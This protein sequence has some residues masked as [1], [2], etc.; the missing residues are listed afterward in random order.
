M[1][2]IEIIH[3]KKNNISLC[4]EEIHYFIENLSNGK[5]ADYQTAAL[6]MAIRL[7]GLTAEET[8]LLTAEMRDSGDQIDLSSIDGIKVDKHSTGGVADTT[9]LISIPIA[10]SCGV[11]IAKMSGRGLGHTGGTLDK[12]ESIP[13]YR[14]EITRA[15]FEQIISKCGCSIIGQSKK[16]VPAD[17]I[18]YALRDVT[19]TV[20]SL[21]LIASSIM[22]KKLASGSNSIVLDVKT[23]SG[24]FMQ[25]TADSLKLA[26]LMCK[27]GNSCGVKTSA[28]IT[29]M[30]QPLGKAIGN[31]IEVIEAVEILKLNKQGR[32]TTLSLNLAAAMIVNSSI[33]ADFKKAYKM[34]EDALLSGK[35]FLKL[36]KMVSLH[37]G[38][39]SVLD[40]CS[41]FQ[42]PAFVVKM[43]SPKEG[44]IHSMQ[45][46]LIGKTSMLLGAGREKKGDVIDLSAGIWMDKELGDKVKKGDLL[47]TFYTND[48]DKI[49][50]AKGIFLNAII[51]SRFKTM[52]RPKLIYKKLNF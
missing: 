42:K 27:I 12:L 17:K 33:N 11:K 52:S 25:K 31:N 5:I 32:L 35:A 48:K 22:S 44:Y 39:I 9:T 41:K 37:G 10:A 6:L 15:K 14:S 38:D 50:K 7:N 30:N 29:D 1:N 4:K 45:T 20:D 28:F 8:T 19:S 23:G 21:P 36:K 13:G 49:E 46:E 18:L 34:A 40:D 43:K 26:K 24:A 3:K 16:L 51:I 2:I 47:A